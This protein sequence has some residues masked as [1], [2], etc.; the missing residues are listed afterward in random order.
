MDVKNKEFWEKKEVINTQN[1][2]KTPYNY[3]KY[4]FK[5]ATSR[6]NKVRNF[7]AANI[8]GCG[9][10][11]DIKVIEEHFKPKLIVA[12]DISENMIEGCKE[13]LK[14]WNIKSNV[15]LHV[16]DASKLKVD[17]DKFDLVTLLNSMLTY[18]PKRKN[19]L[20]IFQNS[21]DSL[22]ERGVVIGVVHNQIGRPMKT[23]YFRLRKLF[24]FLLK[25]KVGNKSTG[26]KG[27]KLPGYYYDKKWLKKDLAHAGFKNISIMSLEEF[28]QNTG[29]AYDKSKSY[30]QLIF[31]CN[32]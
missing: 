32:K 22:I 23:Y 24:S 21:Y 14:G 29:R 28:F 20:R 9:T 27:Y 7:E 2:S 11:R 4:L 3:E 6:L 10:G 5:E 12:S 31:I 8:Y 13:N 26:F 15:Q 1:I 19:R 18:V 17:S 25:D 30:N 16:A